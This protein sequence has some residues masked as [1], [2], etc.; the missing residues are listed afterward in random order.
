MKAALTSKLTGLAENGASRMTAP[1]TKVEALSLLI[2]YHARSNDIETAQRLLTEASKIAESGPDNSDKAKAFFL[3][4][5]TSDQVDRSRKADLISS[6]VKALNSLS[7]PDTNARENTI[8][9]TYVQRLDNAGYE[10]TRG[11]KGLTKQDENA[12][13]ALVDKVQKPDL[14]T[15]AL[16]G[17][18]LGLDGL[19]TESP[20]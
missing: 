20:V 18:L 11:F 6:G 4:S 13:L 16:I 17:I 14:R 19:L 3:L 10:L 7:T 9:Q 12:A 15:F 8:Y 2:R 1:L 5:L